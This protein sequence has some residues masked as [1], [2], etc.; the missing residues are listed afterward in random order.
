M[1]NN[2]WRL[3]DNCPVTVQQHVE[4]FLKTITFSHLESIDGVSGED[5]DDDDDDDGDDD[6]GD[7]DAAPH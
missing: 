7:D 3:L 5:D 6:G 1:T 4:L 2:I